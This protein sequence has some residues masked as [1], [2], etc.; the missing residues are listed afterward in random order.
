[1]I[2]AIILKGIITALNHQEQNKAP[3]RRFSGR[4]SS[5][6]R[7]LFVYSVEKTKDIQQVRAKSQS[8]NKKK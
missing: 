6:P 3:S 7:R 8:R 5:Q 4:F 2:G 1:M